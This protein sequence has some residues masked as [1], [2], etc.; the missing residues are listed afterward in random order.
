M[1]VEGYIAT[2]LPCFISKAETFLLRSE[3]SRV[4]TK[5]NRFYTKTFLISYFDTQ[6]KI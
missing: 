1:R 5:K 6:I 3:E 2:P 4:H